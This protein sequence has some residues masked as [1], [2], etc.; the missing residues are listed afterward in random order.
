MIRRLSNLNEYVAVHDTGTMCVFVDDGGVLNDNRIRATEYEKHI[1]KFLGDH[2]G[3]DSTACARA[4]RLTF[5]NLWSKVNAKIHTFNT[6]DD[7][8]QEYYCD[9]TK[10]MRLQLGLLPVTSS[11][12][13]QTTRKAYV[14]A[15]SMCES[16][17]P[18][19]VD[20]IS[21]I[22]SLGIRLYTASGTP[23]WELEAI[24]MA[25]KIQNYFEDIFGPDLIG[26][27]KRSSEFY[28]RIFDSVGI[29]PSSAVVIESDKDACAWASEAGA[30]VF[31]MG[32]E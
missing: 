11:E 1:G 10:E 14:Y 6:Y 7:F 32:R 13:F 27:P 31:L 5:A 12:A 4:N 23:S 22:K 16:A 26:E 29:S 8:I 19:L 3:I 9:W 18:R 2:W 24:L 15:G 21:S 17:F 20:D 30:I 28:R 25:S